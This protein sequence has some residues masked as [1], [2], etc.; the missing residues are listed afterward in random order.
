ML[1]LEHLQSYG[2]RGEAL[3]SLC[4]VSLVSIT[5]KTQ[6]D[7]VA[8][9]YMYDNDGTIREVKSSHQMNGKCD[10]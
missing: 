8:S 6:D 2:F 7:E 9:T 3:H 5:T 10:H 1:P 4:A